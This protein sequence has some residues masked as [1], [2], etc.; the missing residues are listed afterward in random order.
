MLG[1]EEFKKIIDKAKSKCKKEKDINKLTLVYDNYAY[2]LDRHLKHLEVLRKAREKR[3]EEE[4]E[5]MKEYQ[6]KYRE[7]KKKKQSIKE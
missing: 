4:K 3:S 6:K 1:L 7:D 2:Y 5:K